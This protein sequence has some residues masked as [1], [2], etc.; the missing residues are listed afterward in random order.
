MR[1]GVPAPAH[2]SEPHV[3]FAGPKFGAALQAE[4]AACD[5]LALVSHTENFGATV[6]D[7][8]AHGKPVIT[9]TQT[10]WQVVAERGCGWWVA[11]EVD[12]LAATLRA[13]FDTPAAALADMGRRGRR[14][15]EERYTWAAVA[16][17]MRATYEVV[18][19]R[20]LLDGG[21]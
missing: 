11:N 10:P 16:E 6:V 17:A 9:S 18:A 5:L 7:A 4:Y 15:V 21:A 12:C 3:V 2:G 13:A 14:L 19:A 1:G 8:L 20:G